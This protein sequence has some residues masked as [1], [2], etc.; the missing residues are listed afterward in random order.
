M[1]KEDVIE[2][3]GI[4]AKLI[5]QYGFPA[6]MAIINELKHEEITQEDIQYLKDLVRPPEEY[7][8]GWEK[9]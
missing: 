8:P 3:A 4:I 9:E 5:I 7:F 2:F 1:K 6:A